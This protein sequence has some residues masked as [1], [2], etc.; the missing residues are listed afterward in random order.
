M[1]YVTEFNLKEMLIMG[2]GTKDLI[3]VIL[4]GLLA[5]Y[6]VTLFYYCLHTVY[7]TAVYVTI[8]GEKVISPTRL[9]FKIRNIIS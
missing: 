3:L 4:E 6:Y 8:Y 5:S 2:Q 7:Y 1:I 9:R